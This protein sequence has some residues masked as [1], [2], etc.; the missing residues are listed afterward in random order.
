MGEA[1]GL[2]PPAPQRKQANRRALCAA[3]RARAALARAGGGRRRAAAAALG[4][5]LHVPDHR[6]G[7]PVGF[8]AVGF[9]WVIQTHTQ[10][11]LLPRAEV[12]SESLGVGAGLRVLSGRVGRAARE[13]SDATREVH[14]RA[15][16]RRCP[17]RRPARSAPGRSARARPCGRRACSAAR[18]RRG[19]SAT[20]GCWRAAAPPQRRAGAAR[21]PRR[22]PGA[23][24][25]L[26]RSSPRRRRAPV[27]ARGVAP[28]HTKPRCS[29][30]GASA[31]GSGNRRKRPWHAGTNERPHGSQGVA[32]RA[33]DRYRVCADHL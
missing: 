13:D 23:P 14:A 21:P 8:M 22:P 7:A 17:A 28:S 33:I 30:G 32:C 1:A 5:H 2:G 18:A 29:A 4:R 24:G 26:P 9:A 10:L 15:A 3:S 27:S 31:H 16:G 6:A 25:T 12:C 19:P 20:P 11:A